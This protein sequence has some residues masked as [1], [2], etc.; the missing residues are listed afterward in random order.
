MLIPPAKIPCAQCGA[1]THFCVDCGE[2]TV[3]DQCSCQLAGCCDACEGEC[4]GMAW[5][6]DYPSNRR[7]RFRVID[8]GKTSPS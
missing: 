6:E 1:E 3:C 7:R 2:D 8:G 5:P 4:R